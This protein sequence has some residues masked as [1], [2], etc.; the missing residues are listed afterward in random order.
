[1]TSPSEVL[2]LCVSLQAVLLPAAEKQQ[3]LSSFTSSPLLY[4][5]HKNTLIESDGDDWCD[6]S[7]F[8]TPAC[9]HGIFQCRR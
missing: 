8:N 4:Q 1:M 9:S 5:W 6:S 7:I 3:N 2:G